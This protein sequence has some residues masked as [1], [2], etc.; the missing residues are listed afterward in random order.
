M[1][2]SIPASLAE[3]VDRL[4]RAFG[5]ASRD[6]YLVGG[7][8]RDQLLRL[9]LEEESWTLEITTYR[10]EQYLDGTRKPTVEFGTSL[11]EDLARRDFTMNAL[12]VDALPDELHDPFCGQK[13]I[14]AQLIRA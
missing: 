1:N 6:L 2:L 11:R 4:A 14:D 10:T 5:E 12:A 13:D 9:P 3:R 8:V 7:C